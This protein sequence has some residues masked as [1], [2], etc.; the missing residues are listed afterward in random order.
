LSNFG[1]GGASSKFTSSQNLFLYF[2]RKLF[3]PVNVFWGN[4]WNVIQLPESK[5]LWNAGFS[6]SYSFSG[7]ADNRIFLKSCFFEPN[8][9]LVSKKYLP[10]Q[11]KPCLLRPKICLAWNSLDAT[12]SAFKTTKQPLKLN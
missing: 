1:H 10:P 12:V 8:I 3:T 9:C 4:N 2:G 7:L 6:E 5:T 11:K